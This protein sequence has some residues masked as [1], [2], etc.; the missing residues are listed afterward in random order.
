MTVNQKCGVNLH[1]YIITVIIKFYKTFV[2]YCNLPDLDP[3]KI[4]FN[5]KPPVGF[6]DSASGKES[7]LPRQ[8]TQET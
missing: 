8:E 5:Q 3:A 6:P 1:V 4:L 7:G 2:C